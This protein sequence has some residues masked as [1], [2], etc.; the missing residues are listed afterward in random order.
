MATYKKN[1]FRSMLDCKSEISRIRDLD[2]AKSYKELESFVVSG[3]YSSYKDANSL[4]NLSLGGYSDE[5]V[6]RALGIK[7]NTLRVYRNRVT[8]E[9]N[10]LFG[11]DFFELLLNYKAKKKE[12][13]RRLRFATKVNL[14]ASDLVCEELLVL[15]KGLHSGNTYDIEDCKNEIS[16]LVKY[17]KSAVSAS[18]RGIDRDKLAYLIFLLNTS[19]DLSCKYKLM[20]L[21]ASKEEVDENGQSSM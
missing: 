7:E 5:Y 4:A 13:E 18:L 1:F 19:G 21:L 9:L 3:V 8:S 17:S 2:A 10:D 16:I 6:A 11:E 12:I 14:T 15:C 20:N